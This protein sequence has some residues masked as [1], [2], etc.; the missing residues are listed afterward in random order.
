MNLSMPS[1]SYEP[2]LFERDLFSGKFQNAN[3]YNLKINF[4]GTKLYSLWDTSYLLLM[5]FLLETYN[6]VFFLIFFR[7][8]NFFQTSLVYTKGNNTIWVQSILLKYSK[9]WW[10]GLEHRLWKQPIQ[11]SGPYFLCDFSQVT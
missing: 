2:T 9:L 4:P 11:G 8:F 10:G 7:R 3:C 1:T 5:T 6:E